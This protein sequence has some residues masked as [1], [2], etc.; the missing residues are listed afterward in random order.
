MGA[1]VVITCT[2]NRTGKEN[3]SSVILTCALIHALTVT[4]RA[5]SLLPGG[6]SGIVFCFAFACPFDYSMA[7]K[8][9]D[10]LRHHC[11]SISVYKWAMSVDVGLTNSADTAHTNLLNSEEAQSFTGLLT[12]FG[13][14][15]R[16]FSLRHFSH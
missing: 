15:L 13:K 3:H 5:S 8:A 11:S 16:S 7:I 9:V 1:N 2:I 4:S 10:R 6:R 14:P 12:Y